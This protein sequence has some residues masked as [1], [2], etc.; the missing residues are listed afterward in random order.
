MTLYSDLNQSTPTKNPYVEDF[1]SVHQALRN[2]LATEPK[3]RLFRMDAGLDFVLWYELIGN[4]T[5]D[6][7]VDNLIS[8]VPFQDNRLR[9][10]ERTKIEVDIDKNMVELEIYMLIEGLG[11]DKYE[12]I[13]R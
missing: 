12:L 6:Y 3:Q 13:L 4:E 9:F 1:Y 5:K 8:V 10:D 2:M 7:I 11:P